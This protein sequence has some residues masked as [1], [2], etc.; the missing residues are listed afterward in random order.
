MRVRRQPRERR[1]ATAVE[2]AFVYPATFLLILGLVVVA[3]GVARYQEVASLARA[4]SRYASTHG[5]Q[6]RKDAGLGAGTAGTSTGTSNSLFWY[7]TDP[8]QASGS[9]ATWTGSTYDSAVRPNLVA[10]DPAKL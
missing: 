7:A 6:Y 2:C 1:A 9:D 8:T 4:A 10:L 3:Q 5:A